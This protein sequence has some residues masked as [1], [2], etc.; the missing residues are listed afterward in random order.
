MSQDMFSSGEIKEALGAVFGGVLGRLIA[1]TVNKE[2]MSWAVMLWQLP[3]AIGLG[4]VGAAAA[5]LLEIKGFPHLATSIAFAYT[6]PKAIE[7][8]FQSKMK[9]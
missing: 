2:R 6:G 8:W 5:D 9:K 1:M 4:V 7:I 3:V